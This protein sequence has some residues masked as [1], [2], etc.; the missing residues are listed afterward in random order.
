MKNKFTKAL[1]LATALGM[2]TVS[3]CSTKSSEISLSEPLSLYRTHTPAIGYIN[4]RLMEIS[5]L[6]VG[7]ADSLSRSRD[8]IKVIIEE[9]DSDSISGVLGVQ[10][11][12]FYVG[13]ITEEWKSMREI[14]D[15]HM[16]EYPEDVK[17]IYTST[18][19]DLERVLSKCNSM[20]ASAQEED[21]DWDKV[22]EYGGRIAGL[23]GSSAGLGL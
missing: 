19:S 16:D 3:G 9:M 4:K 22:S 5:I 13:K 23:L 12:G 15:N 18:K 17:I 7:E 6:S 21:I 14:L 1:V 8:I 11:F 2:L 20:L 10:A